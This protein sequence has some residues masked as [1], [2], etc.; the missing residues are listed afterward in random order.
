MS[1]QMDNI[2]YDDLAGL[3]AA[4]PIPSRKAMA[5]AQGR[6]VQAMGRAIG[7]ISAE[8]LAPRLAQVQDQPDGLCLPGTALRV[9][10]ADLAS[11]MVA[12][13]GEEPAVSVALALGGARHLGG[14]PVLRALALGQELALRAPKASP[15]LIAALTGLALLGGGSGAIAGADG[16]SDAADLVALLDGPHAS[17]AGR[18]EIDLGDWGKIWRSDSAETPATERQLWD[19]FHHAT[20]EQLPREHIAP[21][22]E[23]LVTLDELDDIAKLLRLAEV[24]TLHRRAPTKVVFAPPEDQD[25][26][27]TTWVP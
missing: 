26:P 10:A 19:Q 15:K 12:A 2:S 22:F 20:A 7:S 14:K 4:P 13:S 11:L 27:E 6:V 17:A 18:L 1:A 16:V 25:T 24:S 5:L 21:L 8:G 23:R 3:L 9:G